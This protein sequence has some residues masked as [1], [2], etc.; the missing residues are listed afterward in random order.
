MTANK[1]DETSKIRKEMMRIL[2]KAKEYT[3]LNKYNL[4]QMAGRDPE[5]HGYTSLARE[6]LAKAF[7]Y[8]WVARIP[9]KS[10]APRYVKIKKKKIRWVVEEKKGEG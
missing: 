3:P 1:A 4:V 2:E 5:K 10:G 7:T 6:C 8:M 9:G